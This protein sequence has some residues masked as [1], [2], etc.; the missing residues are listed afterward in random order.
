MTV[1]KPVLTTACRSDRFEA[2]Q[3][4]S[5]E[6]I[7]KSLHPAVGGWFKRAHGEMTEAQRLAIPPIL[8]GKSTLLCSPTGTGKTLA[9]FLGILHHLARRADKD[10]LPN[11]VYVLYISPLRALAYDIRK[12][13]DP[14]LTGLG[15]REKIR[16]ATR[17][18]DTPASERAKFRTRPPHLFLTTPESL[19]IMLSQKTLLPK[20]ASCRYV[21]LDEIHSLAENKRGSHL[22]LSLER[23]ERLVRK[24]THGKTGLCRIGLSATVAPVETMARF[25]VGEGRPD[26]EPEPRRCVIAQSRFVRRTIAEVFSPIRENP[27]PPAGWTGSRLVKELS[28]LIESRQSVLVFCNT[29]SGAEN[30]GM[31]LKAALPD[32]AERIAVHHSSLD[33]DVRLEVEDQLKQGRLR[34]VVCSTSLEMGIDIGA[35]DL[36]VMMAAPKGI[37]RAIQRIGRSGHSV[38]QVSHG[39]LCATNIG[40]LIECTA[41]AKLVREKQLDSV[42]VFE[43]AHDVIAQHVVGLAMVE[44]ITPEDLFATLRAAYPF[45]NLPWDEFRNILHFLEGGGKSLR[46]QY[47]DSFGRVRLNAEDGK[48]YPAESKARQRDYLMNI[49]TIISEA[50][51]SVRLNNRTIGTVEEGFIKKLNI[52]DIFVLAGKTV[53]L[54]GTGIMEARV[55]DASGRLPTVPAWNASKMPLTSGLAAE[56]V[57]IRTAMDGFIS[58]EEPDEE[59][60][61]EW[62]IENYEVSLKN[63]EAIVE[64]FLAQAKYSLIPI[65]GRLLIEV[66]RED[67]LT[68]Y[69]FHSLIGR[70]AND[71]LSR[72]IALR[73]KDRLGGNAMATIDDYGFLLTLRKEQEMSLEEWRELFSPENVEDDLFTQLRGAELVK[74]QFRGIAQTGLMVPRQLPGRERRLKQLHWNSEILFQVLQEHEP[75]HPLLQQAYYEAAHTFLDAPRATG[76]LEAV[77][78][79]EWKMVDVIAV[80]PFSFGIYVSKIRETMNLEDPDAAIERLYRSMY[81]LLE[82]EG[83]KERSADAPSP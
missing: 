83:R 72:I 39:I 13:L 40:D 42:R 68:N 9:G 30:I 18:G 11:G 24:R 59:G 19:A 35:V 25:L 1:E 38:H 81:E 58:R 80:T 62:L 74:W 43:Q 57:K 73:V 12:N 78:E 67:G 31:R 47:K 41:T 28:Y 69:F 82:R 10:K 6:A 53:R 14:P 29:R 3:E 65:K 34:A 22:I 15:L 75:D 37:S 4:V 5:Q 32:L 54:L 16:L 44:A 27:Y 48:L 26:V 56:V 7:L 76:F 60:A 17:T 52:G 71:A 33:R 63:A 20:L 66:F 2:A 36:V 23:L 8:Q 64:Q 55:E 70:S 45:R 61:L 49:G 79:Y 50:G 77:T 46:R 51:V 21:I